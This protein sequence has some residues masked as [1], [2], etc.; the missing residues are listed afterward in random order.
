MNERQ[1]LEALDGLLL[2]GHIE[3]DDVGDT[4]RVSPTADVHK[5]ESP[6]D[7]SDP[8]AGV[9]RRCEGDYP[10]AAPAIAMTTSRATVVV[11]IDVPLPF[12]V[13]EGLK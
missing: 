2:E 13:A 12:D 11:E 9:R 1:L 10:D 6:Q 4:W 3:L 8:P 5:G 7:L